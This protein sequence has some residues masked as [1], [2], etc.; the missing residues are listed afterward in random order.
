MS[1]AQI[2]QI[3]YDE[4]SRSQIDDGFKGLDNASAQVDGWYEFSP[5]FNFLESN[6]LTDGVWYG[7]LSP[8][9]TS[10]TGCDA[11]Y[12]YDFLD[13]VP[14][15]A[16]VAIFS[17]GWDQLSYFLN[18]WEQGE[19]WHPTITQI[20][21][22]FLAA[23]ERNVDLKNVVTDLTTSV[24]SNYVIAKKRFWMAWLAIAK[25][26]KQF[27]ADQA[28]YN[29]QLIS[30]GSLGNQVPIKTFIQERLASYLLATGDYV[31]VTSRQT[32]K[33]PVMRRLFPQGETDRKFFML[34][35]QFKRLYRSTQNKAYLDSF[36]MARQQ[37]AFTQPYQK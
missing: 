29:T 35:D 7:F 32:H 20:T 31:S 36:Y 19:L 15:D 23:T 17:P 28:H 13:R 22:E 8:K 10:K 3:F 4:K 1:Q 5:I 14:K 21:Q 18:P 9:F 16:E 11:A 12:V 27:V 37:I 6:S 24:F 30:Y 33:Q 26:F 34:C 2:F 25:E